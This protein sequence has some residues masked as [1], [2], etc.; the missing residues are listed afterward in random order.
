MKTFLILLSLIVV[1][2]ATRAFVFTNNDDAD[3][4]ARSNAPTANY[5]AA[6]SLSVSGPLATNTVSGITNGIADT[7]IRFNTAGTVTNFNALFGTNNWAITGAKLQ[8]TEVGNPN[9]DIFD[10]GIGAFQ[11]YWV[12]DDNWAEGPARP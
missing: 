5:G 8:V 4:F 6:G 9:N 1:T 11:I 12:A 10:Q 3:T 2:N 7:F